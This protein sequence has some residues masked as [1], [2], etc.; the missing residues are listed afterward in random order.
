MA[1]VPIYADSSTSCASV[2][3]VYNCQWIDAAK[4]LEGKAVHDAYPEAEFRIVTYDDI[5]A[6]EYLESDRLD[7]DG[8]SDAT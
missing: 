5:S 7:W 3:Q 6:R 8:L 4:Q 1:K 2:R